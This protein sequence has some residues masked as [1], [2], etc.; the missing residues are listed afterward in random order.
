MLL[1]LWYLDS[2]R[3]ALLLSLLGMWRQRLLR[4]E[5]NTVSLNFQGAGMTQDDLQ[6]EDN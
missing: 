3:M 4:P 5:N 2:P 6:T 1:E